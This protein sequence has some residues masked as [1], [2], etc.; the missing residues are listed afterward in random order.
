M[1]KKK[2]KNMLLIILKVL[3]KRIRLSTL[4]LLAITAASTSFAWFVYATKISTGISAHIETWDIMFTS[5][6]N[7]ISEY[8][9]FTIPNLYPGMADFSDSVSAVN[10]GEV[11]A[12][13]TYEI[14]SVKILG[15]NYYINGTTLTS[16]MMVNKLANDFPFK[17]TFDL[18]NSVA[19]SSYG[20]STFTVSA[21][22]DYESGD[23]AT[24]TYW[25]NQAYNFVN[26]NPGA[27]CIEINVKIMATQ[28]L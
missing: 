18:S 3:A 10:L 17:I 7:S 24:D 9:Y 26:N 11:N 13:V 25:G 8:I 20:M 16:D 4:L 27:A 15:V 2:K 1:E 14:V 28:Q 12:T 21:E 19:S 6:D 5:H 22:W 23:D